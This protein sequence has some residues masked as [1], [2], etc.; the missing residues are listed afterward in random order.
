[1]EDLDALVIFVGTVM[2]VLIDLQVWS[3]AVVGLGLGIDDWWLEINDDE[4]G[5]G[6]VVWAER[7]TAKQ[8]ARVGEAVQRRDELAGLIGTVVLNG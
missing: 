5:L 1:M 3:S 7:D 6:D 4:H 8:R 2:I